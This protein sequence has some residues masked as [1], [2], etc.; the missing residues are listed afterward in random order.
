MKFTRFYFSLI[1]I[2]L[3]FLCPKADAVLLPNILHYIWI[4]DKIPQKYLKNISDFA[5]VN[6]DYEV[7]VWTDHSNLF[8][9]LPSS[10][11]IEKIDRVFP[12][13]PKQLLDYFLREMQAPGHATPGLI[14]NYAAASDILRYQILRLEGGIYLDTDISI[15]PSN[16]TE[17]P[18]SGKFGKIDAPL[19]YIVPIKVKPVPE[20]YKFKFNN[21]MIGATPNHP[22]LYEADLSIRNNYAKFLIKSDQAKEYTIDPKKYGV[23]YNDPSAVVTGTIHNENF[24]PIKL[25]PS[26]SIG[27]YLL[28]HE[29]TGLNLLKEVFMNISFLQDYHKMFLKRLPESEE[30][31]GLKEFHLLSMTVFP[32]I[33]DIHHD[34]KTLWYSA[35]EAYCDQV[36]PK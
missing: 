35:P 29:T 34:N 7:K 36:D 2:T 32:K 33:K 30:S 23:I 22:I 4:G 8:A 11:K 20:G 10:V 3:F 1:A 18:L 12:R 16:T 6:S 27:R 26:G 19:G 14:P 5:K 25:G 28:T 9:N 24:W 21:H 17:A 31:E 15:Q 13:I